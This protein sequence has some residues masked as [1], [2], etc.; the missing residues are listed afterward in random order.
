[1]GVVGKYSSN[2]GQCQI[3]NSTYGTMGVANAA[4]TSSAPT[5]AV[6][7]KGESF[8]NSIN[9]KN[10]LNKALTF[11]LTL[12]QS[13]R[14]PL[15]WTSSLILPQEVKGKNDDNTLA[16]AITLNAGETKTVTVKLIPGLTL[17]IGDATLSVLEENNPLA[18]KSSITVTA[19]S[20]DID[21]VQVIDD[22]ANGQYNLDAMITASGRTDCYDIPS[23]DFLNAASL[24]QNLKYVVWTCGQDGA[25]DATK[26]QTLQSLITAGVPL[27][28]SG[29]QSVSS[30]NT[31]ATTLFFPLGIGSMGVCTQGMG[32]GAIRLVGYPS[33]P[34]SDG[35]DQQCTLIKYLNFGISIN[36]SRKAFPII[37]YG[38][39][40]TIIGTRSITT[41]GKVVVLGFNPKIINNVNGQNSLIK[42]SLDWL[43]GIG[44]QISADLSAGVN[45]GNVPM[46]SYKDTTLV[47]TNNGTEDLTVSAMSIDNFT[48]LFMIQSPAA[49]FNIAAGGTQNVII[50]FQPNFTLP[51]SAN[52][53]ITLNAVENGS[54]VIPISGNGVA[55]SN[56]AKISSDNTTLTF[57]KVPEN[58]SKDLTFTLKNTGN[59]VLNVTNLTVKNAFTSIIYFPRYSNSV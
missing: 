17:G 36:D 55:E 31:N 16:N 9:I 35:F 24:M 34:I 41:N 49:P 38:N 43:E 54:L 56:G 15:D 58:T 57:G 18:V 8:D 52:L 10:T 1:M 5:I 25:I 32:T 50:R 47:L 12:T 3:L 59:Q 26:A 27:L 51:F 13:T 48:D 7:G 45:F 30:I 20:S 6:K 40:D 39:V 46:G 11:S 29:V 21:K 2:A 14:T 42:K 33:D 37:R 19:I 23:T 22:G 44:P 4:V 53:T 28:I